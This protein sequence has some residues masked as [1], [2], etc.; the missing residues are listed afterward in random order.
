MRRLLFFALL[1]LLTACSQI[2]EDERLI[3]VKQPE[4]ARRVLIE[5]FTGQ[6]CVN[7]PMATE[8]TEQLR[9]QYGHENVIVVGIH[10]GPLGFKGS[11]TLVGLATDEGDDYYSHWGVEYQPQGMVDREGGLL[12]YTA[13]SARVYEDIQ[14][15]SPVDIRQQC[16]YDAG[17]GEVVT[18]TTVTSLTGA[19]NAKLQLWVVED[20]ITAMQLRYQEVG[21]PSSGQVTDRNYVHHHVFRQSVNGHWGEDIRIDEGRQQNVVCRFTVAADWNPLQLWVVAF[22]YDATGVLQV[23]EAKVM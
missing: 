13:W 8:E 16:D 5:D 17:T 11:A 2:A 6:R 1:L 21:V 3:Y 18:T 14:K 22:V 19:V 7:C 12:N 9:K 10:S 4:V 23:T 15:T 20:S